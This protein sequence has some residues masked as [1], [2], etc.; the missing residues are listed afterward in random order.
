[1]K[2]TSCA[3]SPTSKKTSLEALV[4]DCAKQVKK[5]LGGLTPDLVLGFISPHFNDHFERVPDVVL[6]NLGPTNFI[7]C[8]A[9][10]IIGG[11]QEIEQTAG[12]AL[13]AAYLP[14][15]NIRAFHINEDELPD[16]DDPPSRWEKL[17]GV[18]Q[19]ESPKFII[20]PDPFSFSIDTFISGLDYCFPQSIKIG[21]L[22]SSASRPGQN[23]LFM[24]DKTFRSGLVGV[25][26]TGDIEVDTVVAQGCRP[27]GR[28]LSVTRCHKNL[29]YELDNK[30]AII[31][32]QEILEN[33]SAHD[34]GLARNALF[35]GVVMDEFKDTFK[36]GDFLIRN[37]LGIEPNTGALVVGEILRNART[38]QFHL[39]DAATSADDLRHLLKRYCD[40]HPEG[41]VGALLF[42]CL[43][44][45]QHLYGHP[46]HDSE[47]FREY[48]GEIPLGGFFCNGEI[49]PVGGTTFLHGYTSSFGI[50]RKKAS[51]KA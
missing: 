19:K 5:A 9:G 27:I 18:S 4:A 50:F 1:M 13:A 25:A 51:A 34:Q 24:N 30:Q 44:R 10:G 3:A 15:V 7:G 49:G 14:E 12:V 36:P 35:L 31:V 17:L 37:I 45:G 33:L 40:E 22:A 6:S 2:W 29:L 20:L 26:M 8:S 16:L 48:L 39:R 28:P 47:C 46:N 42:S 23:A 11:G 32:L 43:G 21:G 41:G 38:V